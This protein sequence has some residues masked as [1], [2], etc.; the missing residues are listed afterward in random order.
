MVSKRLSTR[1]VGEI[2]KCAA[3]S[4]GLDSARYSGYS[5]RSG[6]VT[7][8]AR[9]GIAEHVMRKQT[10]HRL[11]ASLVRYIHLASIFE[12]NSADSLGL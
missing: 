7:Q 4:A 6:Y 2:I 10:G 3:K 8:A 11:H 12:E 5:L 1:V 9:C